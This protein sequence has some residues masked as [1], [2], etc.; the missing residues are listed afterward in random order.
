[1]NEKVAVGN[2][3]TKLNAE[4]AAGLLTNQKI[5]FLIQSTEGMLHGPIAPG[6]TIYVP[7]ALAEQATQILTDAGMIP[8]DG[9]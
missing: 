6:S 2:F 8:D 9:V 3:R 5:P 4:I 1:M 7:Q